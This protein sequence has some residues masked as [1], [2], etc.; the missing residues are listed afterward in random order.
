ML[1]FS[2]ASNTFLVSVNLFRSLFVKGGKMVVGSPN[3]LLQQKFH[4]IG[5]PRSI[6]F[7]NYTKPSVIYISFLLIPR[8]W[9][10]ISSSRGI[11]CIIKPYGL[12]RC[13]P[14]YKMIAKMYLH[15]LSNYSYQKPSSQ[16]NE[17]KRHMDIGNEKH[18]F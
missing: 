2:F 15:A 5:I 11:F 7:F 16:E 9:M 13:M 18:E 1:L 4:D 8:S 3:A 12:V 17:K 14:A 6:F 10:V